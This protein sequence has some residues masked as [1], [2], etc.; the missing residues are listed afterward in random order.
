MLSRRVDGSITVLLGMPV[1]RHLPL[2]I[3]QEVVP[4]SSEEY[5]SKLIQ[6]VTLIGHVHGIW[7]QQCSS[8]IRGLLGRY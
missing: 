1:I 6:S 8:R 3:V 4:G 7:W 2:R 5:M